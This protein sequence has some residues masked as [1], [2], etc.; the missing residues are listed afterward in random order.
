MPTCSLF[1]NKENNNNNNKKSSSEDASTTDSS[2]W[3]LL[4]FARTYILDVVCFHHGKKS[5]LKLKLSERDKRSGAEMGSIVSYVGGHLCGQVKHPETERRFRANDPAFNLPRRYANNAIKTS[6]YNLLTFLPLNLFEQFT[7]LANCFFLFLF[8]LQLIPQI[9]SLA[10]F[11]TAALLILV[12]SITAIKDAVDDVNR[13]KSDNQVN[14]RQVGVLLQGELGTEKWKDV[15]VGDVLKLE[16]NHF[17]PADLLLLSSS[18]PHHVVYVETAELDG[19]TNLKVKQA[20]TVTGEMGE[21]TEA[22]AA[23][24]GEIRCEAPNNRLDAFKGSLTLD[25]QMYALDNDRVL[26]RGCALRNTA[27]C[28]GLVIFCGPDTKLMR[29]GGK[30]TFKRTA[31]DGLMNVLVLCIFLCL[32]SLCSVLAL[33]HAA[34]ERR[35]GGPFAAFLPPEADVDGPLSSFLCFWSYVILLNTAVPMSLFVSVEAIRLVNSFFVDWDGGMYCPESDGGG[36]GGGGSA[37]ARTTALTEELGQVQFV[38]SDKTGTL[39]QNVMTFNKCSIGGKAYGELLDVSGQR[40]QMT[41]DF[42]WNRLADPEFIFHDPA[43]AQS[44]R[45]GN[46]EA[47]AFFRSLALCHTVMAE[48]KAEGELH[49]RAQS[50]D[51]GALVS[52]ARNFGFAFRRRT[53]GSIA[54]DEL[55]RP[56]LYQLLA[57]LD[58]SNV[59]KRMSVIVRGP[60]GRLTLHCK[61]AD[62]AIFPRLHP[63]CDALMDVTARHLDGYARDGLRTLVLAHKDLDE[64]V[65]SEWSGRHHRASLAVSGGDREMDQLY[66]EMEKD[67]LLLG[68]TAVEDKLQDGVPQTIRRLSEAAVKIWVLTGDKRETAENIGYSCGLLREQMDQVFVVSE[69]TARGV[70]G[71]LRCARRT[72]CPTAAGEEEDD[73]GGVTPAGAGLSWLRKTPSVR[74]DQTDGE[75]GLLVDGHSLALALDKDLEAELLRTACLCQTVICCR[76]TP[77]QKAQVVELVKKYKRAVTLAVGDGANDVGM[78]KAAHVGV[79]VSGREGTQAVLASDFSIGRFRHLERLLL[80]HGRWSYLRMCKFLDYFFYK[81]FTF[82]L[83]HVWYAFFCGFSAQTVYDQWF[84]S[85]Y[86]VAYTVLP[87]VGVAVFDQD[88]N[89]RWSLAYP[90]LYSPGP[91]GLYFN[92]KT[93]ACCLMRSCYASLVVFWVPW[94]AMGDAVGDGGG[95]LAHY[96]SFALVV[97]TCLLLVVNIQLCLETKHWTAINVSFM[98]SSLVFYFATTFA[99]HSDDMFSI[100]ASV[101]PFVGTARNSLSQ[102]R[103]WL[104]IFLTCLLCAL[105]PMAFA[106][107]GVQLWPTVNDKV[108]REARRRPTPGPAP[109]PLPPAGRSGARRSGYAFSHSRGYGR[110]L[111]SPKSWWKVPLRGGSAS[112]RPGDSPVDRERA[113]VYRNI[114]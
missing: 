79:G 17:V 20:L 102:P 67:L 71:E 38:F 15:Q 31:I 85:M 52:A 108:R 92:K 27:W 96:Q 112:F 22:L 2:I 18:E 41:E 114:E 105:P 53:A 24:H 73:G 62:S 7:R 36:G 83:V 89:R 28:F 13:H 1:L 111:T 87:V 30:A 74:P 26:L 12:L 110:L 106:L 80:V 21:S 35:E 64:S 58:F 47:R 32:L 37:R 60:D 29:N 55:G 61:G 93:V 94:A 40:I 101:F 84:V 9:S 90:G 10:W 70:G 97:Q 11:T 54:V 100:L 49:Y 82:T 23:F 86:N 95:D 34:W 57:L 104:T 88:V 46:P 68:A 107:A 98:G 45:E 75:Y 5:N 91:R 51:E 44:V 66:E 8:I 14:N 69:N 81:N 56:L 59:R 33:G 76:V 65:F 16:D 78:I 109:P 43:L 6:K 42:S 113:Q 77:L 63:S 99:M 72:M 39:T 4:I 3:R 25:G 50:P 103:V 19:E 48:E